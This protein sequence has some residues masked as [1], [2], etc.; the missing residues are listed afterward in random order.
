MNYGRFGN[1]GRNILAKSTHFPLGSFENEMEERQLHSIHERKAES[2]Y[3]S[4]YAT[5]VLPEKIYQEDLSF[6]S[7]T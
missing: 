5:Y 3:L 6:H 2:I 1:C 4:L 7:M